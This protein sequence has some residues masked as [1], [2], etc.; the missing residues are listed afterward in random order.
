[1][2]ADVERQSR[3]PAGGRAASPQPRRLGPTRHRRGAFPS[4]AGPSTCSSCDASGSWSRSRT[5]PLPAWRAGAA[6]VP[7]PQLALIRTLNTASSSWR[8]PPLDAGEDV[9]VRV[10]RRRVAAGRG[11]NE[12]RRADGRTAQR[13]AGTD[14]R[15]PSPGSSWCAFRPGSAPARPAPTS[16]RLSAH[17]WLPFLAR[18]AAALRPAARRFRVRHALRA[19]AERATAVRS[20][21]S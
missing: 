18:V 5:P 13:R 15:N 19:A 4:N 21:R 14:P 12:R 8:C 11:R 2:Q 10:A 16:T 20:A 9:A 17:D 6:P 1:M 7:C 3:R